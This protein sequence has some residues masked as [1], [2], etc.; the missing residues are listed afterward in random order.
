MIFAL[1]SFALLMCATFSEAKED[2]AM[3]ILIHDSALC[4]R[5]DSFTIN[6]VLYWRYIREV[7]AKCMTLM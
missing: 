5:S 1:L 3:V 4:K 7:I 2:E 6:D